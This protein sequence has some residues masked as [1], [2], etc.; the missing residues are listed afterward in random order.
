MKEFQANEKAKEKA[1]VV[2]EETKKASESL[3]ES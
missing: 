1:E 2:E 3:V